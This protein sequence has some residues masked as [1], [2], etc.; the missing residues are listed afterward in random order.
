MLSGGRLNVR[1]LSVLSARPM[2]IFV[3]AQAEAW[4]F[5]ACYSARH[6]VTATFVQG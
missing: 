1:M 6:L 2:L 4:L 3:T 5:L